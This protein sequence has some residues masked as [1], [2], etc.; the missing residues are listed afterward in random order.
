M[1]NHASPPAPNRRMRHSAIRNPP[2]AIALLLATAHCLLATGPGLLAPGP[3]LL[4][5]AHC[6]AQ[7]DPFAAGVR[8]TSWLS[9]ADEQ[10]AFQLPPGFEINLIAAE[11]DIQ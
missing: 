2:S 5:P 6:L 9:P 4:A 8:T 7:D 11:P 3:W 10:K 1:H